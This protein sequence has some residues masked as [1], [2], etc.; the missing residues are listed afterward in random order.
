VYAALSSDRKTLH[1]AVVN[2]T[3]SAQTLDLELAGAHAAGPARILRLEGSG[4]NAANHVGKP[5][6]LVVRETKASEPATATTVPPISVSIFNI[7]LA[8]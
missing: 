7:P 6:E 1:V 2:A 8:P 3:E 4:L 5:A